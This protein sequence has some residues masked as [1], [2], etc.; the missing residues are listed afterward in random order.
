MQETTFSIELVIG[1]DCSTDRTREI[2]LEYQRKRPDIIRVVLWSKNVG[3]RKNSNKLNE[4]LRGKYVAFCEGDDYWTHPKKLQMQVDIMEANPEIGL[5]HGVADI[6]HVEKRRRIRWRPISTDKWKGEDL[7]TTLILHRDYPRIKT[8]TVCMRRDLFLSILKNNSD[9]Y[10]EEFLMRDAQMWIEASRVSKIEFIYQSLG[11]RNLLPESSS[12]S[13]NPKKRIQFR[14]SSYLLLTHL[15][16]KF[17]YPKEHER[18][19]LSK[20][21][22][23]LLVTAYEFPDKS[24]AIE[25]KNNLDKLGVKLKLTKKIYYYCSTS[26]FGRAIS[27]MLKLF[28]NP[29]LKGRIRSFIANYL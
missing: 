17:N 10:S 26:G 7:L 28:I 13:K 29:R 3:M 2:V 4:L 9:D 22:E 15:V 14:R 12:R 20:I 11:T 6:Y 23:S 25:A 18:L 1:E 19:L 5:V 24:L 27:P 8:L 21:N 16:K